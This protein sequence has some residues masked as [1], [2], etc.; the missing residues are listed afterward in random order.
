MKTPATGRTM[1]G[2]ITAAKDRIKALITQWA[3]AHLEFEKLANAS[4]RAVADLR[5]EFVAVE[6]TL[7]AEKPRGKRFGRELATETEIRQQL[8]AER[9]E[10]SQTTR[11]SLAESKD[12]L[13]DLPLEVTAMSEERN[14]RCDQAT[15]APETLNT[16]EADFVL[17]STLWEA[18][19]EDMNFSTAEIAKFEKQLA[20]KSAELPQLS[21]KHSVLT[22]ELSRVKL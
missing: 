19:W 7:G 6:V 13:S 15:K 22:S 10:A 3:Q 4:S 18:D 12:S 17:Q 11:C 21:T 2:Q 8:L 5:A 20:A 14:E 16:S 9:L 1:R